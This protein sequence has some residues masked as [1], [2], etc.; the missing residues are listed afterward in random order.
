MDNKELARA[1]IN[2][3]EKIVVD[4]ERIEKEI[5]EIVNSKTKQ[6]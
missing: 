3:G 2:E 4:A 5:L 6:M 1:K